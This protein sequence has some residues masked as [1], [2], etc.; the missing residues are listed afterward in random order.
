[1]GTKSSIVWLWAVGAAVL[2]LGS[3]DTLQAAGKASNP[4]VVVTGKGRC[5]RCHREWCP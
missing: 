4:A 1:M 5:A 3:V 2:F